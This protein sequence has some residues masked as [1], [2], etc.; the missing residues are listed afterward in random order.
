[1]TSSIPV[2]RQEGPRVR[3]DIEA[4]RARDIVRLLARHEELRGVNAIADFF[5][6]AVRWTA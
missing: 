4:R 1:M 3:T 6:D 5:D 2:Q